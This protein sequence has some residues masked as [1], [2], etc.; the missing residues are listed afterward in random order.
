MD[1]L[2]APDS[3]SEDMSE[4]IRTPVEMMW[5]DEAGLLRHR[6]D[7]VSRSEPS[8]PPGFARQCRR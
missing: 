7:E 4:P 5:I 3:T 6:L 1:I 8:M 2:A